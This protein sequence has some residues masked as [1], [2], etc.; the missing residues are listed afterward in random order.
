MARATRYTAK[1][2]EL[3]FRN[4]D[5]LVANFYAG[6]AAVQEAM[7]DVVAEAANDIGAL[8]AMLAPVDT[9]F[10]SDHVKE[11]FT[12][13]GLGFEVGWDAADFFE[14]GHAFYP[15][16]QEFG[17]RFM[18]AQPSLGPAYD[19]IIPGF[20]ERISEVATAALARTFAGS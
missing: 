9:G 1:E 7:R 3:G 11:R 17:T 14:A 2:F 20:Q 6:D 5:A 8:A 19:A 15:F 18:P 4:L 16:F 13:S 10:M 12:P